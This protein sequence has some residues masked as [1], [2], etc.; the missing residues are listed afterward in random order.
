ML[1]FHG[2][3]W[4]FS[5]IPELSGERA[6]TVQEYACNPSIESLLEKTKNIGLSISY[7]TAHHFSYKAAEHDSNQLGIHEA[8]VGF[9]VFLVIKRQ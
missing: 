7:R 5:C 4:L 2:I 9:A 6:F 8:Y 3:M 1:L